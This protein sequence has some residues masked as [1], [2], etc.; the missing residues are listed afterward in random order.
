M[1]R[2]NTRYY[3]TKYAFSNEHV[4]FFKS[5]IFFLSFWI[6]IYSVLAWTLKKMCFSLLIDGNYRLFKVV[7]YMLDEYIIRK[8]NLFF[9]K[10]KSTEFAPSTVVFLS[11]LFFLS[12]SLYN[13][14]QDICR[15][16][17]MPFFFFILNLQVMR[18][19]LYIYMLRTPSTQ[20]VIR[21]SI[22]TMLNHKFIHIFWFDYSLMCFN[23]L[24]LNILCTA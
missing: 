8:K 19:F 16:T 1:N 6:K 18:R 23:R 24:I 5:N 12:I 13:F 9:R 4:H 17:V 21:L 20:F 22:F 10:K 15:T 14:M 3:T 7:D 2:L 11:A